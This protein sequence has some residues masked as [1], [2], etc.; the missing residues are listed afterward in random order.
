[1]GTFHVR[2]EIG[3]PTGAQWEAVD[4]IV[5]TGTLYTFIPRPIL[6]RL[7]VTPQER[8]PFVLA[9]GTQIE[10]DVAETRVRLNGTTR[11]TIVIFGDDDAPPLLGTYTLEGFRLGVDP[12]N[13]RLIP[14]PG[15]LLR[16]REDLT[17][18]GA[19][20]RW[21]HLPFQSS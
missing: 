6:E 17:A 10:H 13:R 19:N 11:T 12:L 14:V 7:H 4:T 3:D 1:M 16:G 2:I 9:D 8:F 15:L 18:P 21:T 20:A 5:D